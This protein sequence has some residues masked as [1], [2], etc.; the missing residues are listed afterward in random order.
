MQ[1]RYAAGLKMIRQGIDQALIVR[2]QGL[3]P[4]QPY[5]GEGGSSMPQVLMKSL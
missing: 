2:F 4:P 5:S 1:G 3:K